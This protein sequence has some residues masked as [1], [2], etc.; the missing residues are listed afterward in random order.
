MQ[1]HFLLW[2]WL[3]G[4]IGQLLAQVTADPVFPKAD[5]P[6]TIYYDATK[7]NRALLNY[8][9]I[10]AHMGVITD[11]SQS[12]TD[13]KY[14][15]TIWGTADANGLMD[16]VS[17]NFFKKTFVP[18][19]FFGVPAGEKILQLAFVFR[20]ANGSVVGRAESGS[21]IYYPIYDENVGLL[22][23]FV[24]PTGAF[25]IAQL[26][27]TIAVQGASSQNATLVLSD[28]GQEVTRTTGQK[29]E[30]TLT[31][32]SGLHRIELV[33]TTPTDRSVSIFSYIVPENLSKQDPP[34][35]TPLGLSLA[36]NGRLRAVLQA[37]RKENVY[38]I[39][40]FNDWQPST[41]YQLRNSLNGELWWLE[42]PAEVH[43]PQRVQYLVDGT[44]RIA[45]PYSTLVLD[46][47]NDAAIPAAT[48][49]SI[50]AYPRTKTTGIVT[51]WEASK[52]YNWQ[53]TNYTRP[54]KQNLVIYEL[55][56]RD[57]INLRN[58]QT[59]RD[60]LDYLQQLGVNAIELMPIQEFDD[61]MSWGYNPSFHKALDKAYGDPVAFKRLV[62][63]CHQRGMAVIVDVVFN[64]ATGSSP[65]AQLYWDAANNR[66]A[67]DNPWFNVTARHDFSVFHDFN[68]AYAGTRQ[69]V[70]ACLQYW[71]SEY[72]IDGYRFD[73]SKGLTQ[74][75]TLG[76]VSAWGEYDASRIAILKEYA[77]TI[78]AVDPTAYV[79]L[80]HFADNTEEKELAEAGMMLWGNL[81]SAYKDVALGYPAGTNTDLRWLWHRQRGWAVPH[82]VGYME[83]HDEN[84][85]G[86]ELLSYG[87]RDGDYNLKDVSTAM[88]RIEMLNN[89]FYTVP[90]PKMLWQFGELGYDLPINLC[91]NGMY[92]SSCRT[93]VKPT[94]W[95]YLKEPARRRLYDRT[96]ALLHLR[97]A[98]PSTFSTENAQINTGSGQIR[99][100][101]LNDPSLSVSVVANTGVRETSVS[102]TFAKAGRWYEYYSGQTV[103]VSADRTASL[104]LE[105][106]GY[107]LFTDKFVALPNGISSTHDYAALN[108]IQCAVWPNPAT[109]QCTVELTV[110]TPTTIW[111]RIYN[112]QG[113]LQWADDAPTA[114]TTGTH[115]RTVPVGHWP[116][117][118][119]TVSVN[120]TAGGVRTMQLIR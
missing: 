118:V 36:A 23:T 63:A 28:N 112:A 32:Q 33:A 87:N 82:V 111:V 29:L 19:T 41:A 6:I 47:W 66:T 35:D 93:A 61:N 58:Y 7:G 107:R 83:S 31:A 17:P 81:W 76:N 91:P 94:R 116:K 75:N 34:A 21:D 86:S 101:A 54:Q 88:R 15:K 102:H 22:T 110:E 113:Q 26:G 49:N 100:I 27:Q 8:I 78:A 14:V 44:L 106:G 68:H 80:E 51:W 103:D 20:N 24:A 42:L 46:P 108:G 92:S 89:L 50:P 97:K 16:Y 40:D 79:I 74:K 38:L 3:V 120:S 55:L 56:V 52:S 37:P 12:L 115:T 104:T 73:L 119:Y 48:F 57:F 85:I 95:E 18:R 1:K 99:T 65:L 60:T 71:L 72:R 13:W 77:A 64:H 62:D 98:F 39:G 114:F 2:W 45:D 96:R 67:T 25:Q 10:Y 105:P 5:A 11:K 30:A 43:L 59:L 84:R 109:A 90:G 117:G 4:S 9:P 69:Y 70:K 53:A